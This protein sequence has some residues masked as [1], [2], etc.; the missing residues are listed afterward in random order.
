[1]YRFSKQLQINSSACDLVLSSNVAIAVY[2]CMNE[3][4]YWHNEFEWRK[5]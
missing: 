4:T 2:V 5:R 3:F 1:M